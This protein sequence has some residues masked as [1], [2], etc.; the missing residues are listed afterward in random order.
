M[1]DIGRVCMK[2]AGRDA[3]K[4]CV[5]IDVVDDAPDRSLKPTSEP[6]EVTK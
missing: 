3:G 5:I 2:I 1:F 6:K 4:K